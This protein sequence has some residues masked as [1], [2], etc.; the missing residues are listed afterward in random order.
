MN[1]R[2]SAM[3]FKH[4]AL[5][6]GFRF[7]AAPRTL[8]PVT[9][10]LLAFEHGVDD[11][12]VKYPWVSAGYSTEYVPDN[13][14][15]VTNTYRRG[16]WSNTH[17]TI[18]TGITLAFPTIARI[19]P[20]SAVKRGPCGHNPNVEYVAFPRGGGDV[21]PDTATVAEL[22]GVLTDALLHGGDVRVLPPGRDHSCALFAGPARYLRSDNGTVAWRP[23]GEI[24][25]EREI[26]DFNPNRLLLA[27][28]ENVRAVPW[29]DGLDAPADGAYVV[30]DFDVRCEVA[31]V[32]FS[33]DCTAYDGVNESDKRKI[34]AYLDSFGPERPGPHAVTQR[35]AEPT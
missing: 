3:P 16:A 5:A 11:T 6:Y 18:I 12:A 30:V 33:A 29:P 13:S 2:V 35:P 24:F 25:C 34:A 32:T 28:R 8:A 23:R 14:T 26:A 27:F 21:L 22:Q 19:V 20:A 1:D 9:R 7:D 31:E 10:E 15:D 4:H 17:P